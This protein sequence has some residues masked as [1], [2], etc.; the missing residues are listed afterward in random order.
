M[1]ISYLSR[2]EGRIAYTVQGSGPLLVAIPGMGDLAS[3]LSRLAAELA[4]AGYRVAVMDLRGHGNSDTSFRLHGDQATG[5]DLLALIEQ[6][7]G[8]AVVLGNSMGGSAAVWAAV[9]RPSAIAGLVL[10]S[11]FLRNPASGA[12]AQTM[13]KL[14]YRLLFLPPWGA[15]LWSS[16]YRGF[17]KGRR[18][19]SLPEHVAAI[20]ASLREPG[21]LRSLRELA[22]QLDHQVVE[23]RLADLK[24]PGRVFIGQS[25]PDFSDPAAESAWMK[26]LGLRAELVPESGHYPHLQRPELVLPATVEF[27]T[28]LRQTGLWGANA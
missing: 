13:I 19:P 21:R 15:G 2:P 4:S 20:K 3:G 5:E 1:N 22:V 8:A 18:A 25:D 6:L 24:T 12:F 28:E 14:V 23:D 11:P 9:E 17:N 10:Y 16:L 7:G 27:L 26:G